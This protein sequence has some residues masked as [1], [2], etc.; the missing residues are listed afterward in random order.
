M[1]IGA[2]AGEAT[3]ECDADV[4]LLL[5]WNRFA[6]NPDSHMRAPLGGAA[7]QQLRSVLGGY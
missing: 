3:V 2:P 4:R 1:T 6:P 5:L 7:L